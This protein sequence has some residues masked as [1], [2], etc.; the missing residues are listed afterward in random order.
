MHKF[1]RRRNNKSETRNF[2]RKSLHLQAV[3]PRGSAAFFLIR[4][5][6]RRSN[7]SLRLIRVAPDCLKMLFLKPPPNPNIN[8]FWRNTYAMKYDEIGSTAVLAEMLKL[9]EQQPVLFFKH[10]RTCGVS[11]RAFREFERYLESPESAAVRNCVIVVQT[12]REAS[13]A[14]AH[15]VSVEHESPQAILVRNGRAIWND[16]HLALKSEKLKTAVIQ[17]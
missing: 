13:N 10:S 9:S 12:A 11:D 16:S 5:P 6:F 17:N 1:A 7:F 15:L 8:L 14:L 2:R 3:G 4:K